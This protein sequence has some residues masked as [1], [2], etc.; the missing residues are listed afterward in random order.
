MKNVYRMV[1]VALAAVLL[2]SGCGKESESGKKDKG[3]PTTTGAVI[4]YEDLITP[5]VDR[6]IKDCIT[7]DEINALFDELGLSYNMVEDPYPTD[8]TVNYS[9]IDDPSS[10]DPSTAGRTIMLTL[11]N[12][13]REDFDAIATDPLMGWI[14]LPNV[15][16]AVYWN[17]NQTELIAYE[18]GY[19]FSM[20]VQNIANAA[21]I[22]MTEIVLDKLSVGSFLT[23]MG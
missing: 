15:G 16:E 23:E 11:E 22:G 3:T 5:V 2:L 8:S 4:N 14:A 21:M 9:S 7:V 1:A 12:M 20:S 10:D 17:S 19:A 6:K 13:T 18:N